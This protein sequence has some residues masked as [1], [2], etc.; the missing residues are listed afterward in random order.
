MTETTREALTPERAAKLREGARQAISDYVTTLG[1]LNEIETLSDQKQRELVDDE[2]RVK[3]I[4]AALGLPS[5]DGLFLHA[6]AEAELAKLELLAVYDD[7]RELVDGYT[8][9]GEYGAIPAMAFGAD[10]QQLFVEKYGVTL[11]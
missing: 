6:K 8:N 5:G 7:I 4:L 10:L 3:A 2:R 9:S 11:P 1:I